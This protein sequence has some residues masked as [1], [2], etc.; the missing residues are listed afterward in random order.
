MKSNKNKDLM[1]NAEYGLDSRFKS[2][3]EHESESALLMEARLARMKKLSKDQI[4]R[5]KLMQ[6]KLKMEDH[7]F[8]ISSH[9]YLDRKRHGIKTCTIC[10]PIGDSKSIKEKELYEFIQSVYS[11]E[12]IQSWRDVLEIDVYLPELK[13]GFEFNGIYWHSNKFKDSG[14]HL[15]KTKYFKESGIRIIHIWEDD[16]NNKRSILESQIRNWLGLTV[17]SIFARRCYIKEINNSRISTEFLEKNHIQGFVASNLKLGL[18]YN[19]ELVSLM[20][21]DHLEGRKKMKDDEWNINRFCNRLDTNVIGGAS[22]LLNYFIKNYRVK[23][24]ISYSDQDWSLG[25]LYETL[26]FEKVNENDPDYKYIIEGI[27]VHKSRFR[28]SKTG[29]SENKLNLLKVYDCGK[30]KWEINI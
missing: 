26:G 9:N 20:T 27:R 24:I 7:H 21:F 19:N 15:N 22:K 3:E 25:G 18:F 12:V 1:N 6:L 16:W 11:G 17:N 13:L 5:A 23:R 29:I 8:E 30:T 28:K 2:N 4:I 14:Y 10:N